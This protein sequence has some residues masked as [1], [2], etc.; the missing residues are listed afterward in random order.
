M[1]AY[2]VVEVEITKRE[3]MKPYWDAVPD[4][5]TQY[6]SRFLTYGGSTELIEGGSEPKRIVIVEFADK[7]GV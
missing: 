5:L 4:T 2:F 3:A 6:G 7:S 1:S